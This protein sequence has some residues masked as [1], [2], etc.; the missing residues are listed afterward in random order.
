[1]GVPSRDSRVIW[2]ATLGL[3][4]HLELAWGAKKRFEMLRLIMA[5]GWVWGLGCGV[6]SNYHQHNSYK[7]KALAG[8]WQ[9]P[10]IMYRQRN[11]LHRTYFF[12]YKLAGLQPQRLR[13]ARNLIRRV[14]RDSGVSP[15]PKPNMLS[16]SWLSYPQSRKIEN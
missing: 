11:L 16:P 8:V 5:R 13:F 10:Y 1:M 14:R 3:P 15:N 9:E 6:S 2:I 4:G 7:T 12:C